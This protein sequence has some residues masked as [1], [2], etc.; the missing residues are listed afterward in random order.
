MKEVYCKVNETPKNTMTIDEAITRLEIFVRD[1]SEVAPELLDDA[2]R[3]GIEALKR[4]KW[5]RELLPS[6]NIEQLPKER[7]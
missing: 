1:A 3:L 2:I 6:W 7:L 5:Y 4:I